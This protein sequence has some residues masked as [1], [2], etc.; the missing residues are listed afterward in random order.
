MEG[1]D[2]LGSR[3]EIQTP[4]LK[5]DLEVFFLGYPDMSDSDLKNVFE[6]IASQEKGNIDYKLLS[7]EITTLPKKIFSF[8]EKHGNTRE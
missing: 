8:L 1:N 5:D 7:R 3:D 2:I 4:Y 6:N